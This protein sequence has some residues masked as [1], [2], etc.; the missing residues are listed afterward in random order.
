[1]GTVEQE[2]VDKEK[3]A[4]SINLEERTQEIGVEDESGHFMQSDQ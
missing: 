3:Q 2:S 1:M 4:A